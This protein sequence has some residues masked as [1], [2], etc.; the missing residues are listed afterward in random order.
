MSVTDVMAVTQSVSGQGAQ[1]L[2]EK[3]VTLGKVIPEPC[4]PL[5]P[6]LV[7]FLVDHSS[8][9]I[10]AFCLALSEV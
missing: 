5:S 9:L 2:W 3:S 6:L 8:S 4:H 1:S 10:L 7:N